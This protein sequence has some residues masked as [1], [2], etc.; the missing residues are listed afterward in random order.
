MTV[1]PLADNESNLDK[2]ASAEAKNRARGAQG[3]LASVASAFSEEP[4]ARLDQMREALLAEWRR[5]GA[6][7]EEL[8]TPLVATLTTDRSLLTIELAA[9]ALA[10]QGEDGVTA[11]ID[12]LHHRDFAVRSKA[13]IAFG[14]LDQT[15]RWAVPRLVE[16]LSR[17]PVWLV[18]ADLVRALGRI[19]G[20]N[21]RAALAS[22]IER[23]HMAE[24]KDDALLK[25][26]ATALANL[27][28]KGES[29]IPDRNDLLVGLELDRNRVEILLYDEFNRFQEN[30][31]LEEESPRQD[32]RAALL[33]WFM[34]F[35]PELF[36]KALA[37]EIAKYIESAVDLPDY[38]SFGWHNTLH[39]R[40][41]LFS[42]SGNR[43][44]I[45]H[46]LRNL[47]HEASSL[48]VH[49]AASLAPVAPLLAADDEILLHQIA[50][51]YTSHHFFNHFALLLF[52]AAAGDPAQK[53]RQLRLWRKA[54]DPE[55]DSYNVLEPLLRGEPVENPFAPYFRRAERYVLLRLC[56]QQESIP[57][58]L[59][60]VD[61]KP[62]PAAS[63]RIDAGRILSRLDSHPLAA[64]FAKFDDLGS[65]AT[66]K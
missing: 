36:P 28:A 50:F 22:L 62:A 55:A 64:E 5:V 16:A 40:S 37:Y 4:A 59:I 45:D 60:G 32:M 65:D 35:A 54:F 3:I 48:R 9:M 29:G 2:L 12:L 56:G 19:G 58:Q 26:A 20:G 61:R 43:N 47:G 57:P 33:A 11:L 53:Q 10:T 7:R 52:A 8:V 13:V 1:D 38:R 30:F 66:Q 34:V 14:L 27:D 25:E 51:N 39:L 46:S 15:S 24:E 31:E 63:L 44:W 49:V 21:A 41:G 17:E 23:L 42:L 18:S 6:R